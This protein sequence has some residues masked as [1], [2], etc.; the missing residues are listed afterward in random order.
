LYEGSIDYSYDA[1]SIP[2]TGSGACSFSIAF[3][4]HYKFTGKE[5]DSESGLDNFEAR[6]YV[7]YQA[8]ST[9]FPDPDP[10]AIRFPIP[11]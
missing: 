10:A 7:S 6:Y 9:M 3:R 11:G 1:V 4:D 5:R 8:L 2:V